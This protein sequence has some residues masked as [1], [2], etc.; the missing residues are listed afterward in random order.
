VTV[1]SKRGET[2]VWVHSSVP[3]EGVA[4]CEPMLCSDAETIHSLTSYMH[5]F[6]IISIVNCLVCLNVLCSFLTLRKKMSFINRLRRIQ[7]SE[8]VNSYEN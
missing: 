4:H 8:E 5:V 1:P 6:L 3:F 7:Q 2:F